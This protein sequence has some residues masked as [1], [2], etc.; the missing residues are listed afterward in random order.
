MREG[1][2]GGEP[3]ELRLRRVK[4]HLRMIDAIEVLAPGPVL[5]LGE[6]QDVLCIGHTALRIVV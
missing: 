6:H 2:L 1:T 3:L 4:I 5:G